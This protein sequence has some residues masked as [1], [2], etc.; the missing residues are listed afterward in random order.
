MA[1]DYSKF[2]ASGIPG[3]TPRWCFGC[4]FARQQAQLELLID[5]GATVTREAH[6]EPW[7]LIEGWIQDP[8]GTRIVLV[9]VPEEHPIRRDLRRL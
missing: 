1:T 7:G 3:P 9:Q 2:P 6:K 4:R 5:R 8:D